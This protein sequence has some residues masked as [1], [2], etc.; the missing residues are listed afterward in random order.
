MHFVNDKFLF[1]S[2]NLF[3]DLPQEQ[4]EILNQNSVTHAYKKGEIVFR[5]DG[6]PMGIYFLKK[7]KV[8]KYKNTFDGGEQIFYICDTG[9]LFGYHALLSGEHY[10]DSAATI[11]DSVITF[12]PKDDFFSVLSSSPVLSTRLLKA[13]SHEFSVFINNITSLAKKSV[14]ERV[15]LN[16]LIL[17]EKYKEKGKEDLLVEINMSRSDLASMSGTAKET[18]VRLLHDFKDEKLI[19]TNGRTI[20]LLNRPGLVKVANF[21]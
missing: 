5:E 10:P 13:L 2:G 20:R 4:Q 18:L 1:S 9:E 16:L 7:G 8:K 3:Q 19:E 14:R 6:I 15:A 11:E 17:G 12:I 21:Y